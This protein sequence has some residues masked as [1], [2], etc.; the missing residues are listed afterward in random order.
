MARARSSSPRRELGAAVTRSRRIHTRRFAARGVVERGEDLRQIAHARLSVIRTMLPAAARRSV[1][2]R[3]IS[4][5][6]EE[7]P[8]AVLAIE[9]VRARS[10]R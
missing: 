4:F 5:A 3:S 8:A 9:V 2:T 1:S 6:H 7:Q 10:D